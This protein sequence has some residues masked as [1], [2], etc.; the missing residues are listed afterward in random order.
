M[1]MNTIGDS[2]SLVFE[3]CLLLVRHFRNIMTLSPT[4]HGFN[5]RIF[6]YALHPEINFVFAG[7][8]TTLRDGERGYPEH[9]VPC[10]YMIKQIQRLIKEGRMSERDMASLLQKHWK[11]ALIAPEEQK[12]L[13]SKNGKGWKDTMPADWTFESGH[14]FA[15]LEGAGICLVPAT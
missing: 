8:S 1:Q 14:T 12:E 11:I 7:R 5:S 6:S 10:A 15:R 13:D 3:T 9:V 2:T 4:G